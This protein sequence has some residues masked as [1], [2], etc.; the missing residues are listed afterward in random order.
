MKFIVFLLILIALALTSLVVGV[1]D[2]AW[3]ALL[4]VMTPGAETIAD[5]KT[6]AATVLVTSRIPRT[7]ALIL[8]GV[9]LSVSGLILQ[10][11]ARNKFVEPHTVGASESAALGLLIVL[12]I[13]PGLP[14][15]ARMLVATGFA[16]AG[17]ALFLLLLQRI[18][19]RTPYIVPLVGLMLGGVIE[20]ATNFVGYRT[21]MMQAL[22][23]WTVG[24]FSSILQGRYELLWLSLGLTIA[25]YFAADRFTVA[26]MGETVST[27]LGL[28][29]RRLVALGLV[30]VSL[31]TAVV[32][33]TSGM[34]PFVGLIVPNLVT[35]I[36]GD[37]MRR[38]LPWV[39]AT[40][41][42]LLLASDIVG[43]LIL[44]PYELPVGT[45]MGVVGGAV[46]LALL[47]RNMRHDR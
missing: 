15:I 22:S 5:D 12:L 14:I 6:D 35:L 26:A 41:A 45:T 47:L 39:A 20:A 44:H 37:N 46:F 28:N 13:T 18:P 9:G 16:M 23:N 8:A 24:D 34:I 7:L 3:D 30:V 25:A 31:M 43:R 19:W 38:N 11:L 17:S 32:I 29:Y 27:S 33:V 4:H 10:M 21:D 1:T 36:L 2:G 42:I 40:G